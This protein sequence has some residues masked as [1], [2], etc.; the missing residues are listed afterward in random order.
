MCPAVLVACCSHGGGCSL[1]N[2]FADEHAKLL[3]A[4]FRQPDWREVVKQG[5][6]EAARRQ[7]IV[8]PSSANVFSLPVQQLKAI[9]EQRVRHMIAAG[10]RDEQRLL[11]ALGTWPSEWPAQLP[12]RLSFLGLNLSFA[13]DMQPHCIYCNQQPVDER[14][15][16]DDWKALVL[17]VIP[18]EEEGPYIFITGGEPLL[19]GEGLWGADG[20]IRSATEAGAAFNVN[21]NALALTPRAALGLVR[22]GLS[23]VHI[24]L[25]THRPEVQNA[26]HRRQ[27]RWAQ[28]VRGIH[29]IQIA[30][31]LLA[32]EHPVIHINCVLTRMNAE[33]FPG[34]L[35]FVLGMKPLVKGAI[36]PDFDLHVIPVGGER[37]QRFRLTAEGYQKFFTEIWEAANAVWQEY[38]I[39]RRIPEDERG[40][41]HAKM[42]FLS[43][44]HRVQQR[45]DLNEWA[46]R[47]ARGLPASLSLTQRCYVAPTQGFILPDGAQYWCG[48][49]ATSRPEPVGNVLERGIQ[50]N[51]RRGLSQMACLP[52]AHCYSCAGATQAIN[53]AVEASLGQAV[54][55][56]L[57]PEAAATTPRDQSEPVFE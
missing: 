53:Q 28:V 29:N 40:P 5:V 49:H 7:M 1:F 18:S 26:I 6:V 42:P 51:I 25:D 39:A 14:M 55:E 43:P 15:K 8:P 23:R 22:T 54:A 21:T 48:G 17:S 20:L 32:V 27:G 56:W 57:N 44:Y 2:S 12:V 52:G 16:L 10:E 4:V 3:E 30:K 34:F 41:L 50:E 45:G 9:N 13:C 31:A 19:F 11:A 33:D 38:Q 46:D 24:S 37:N 35:R 36:S 47:A